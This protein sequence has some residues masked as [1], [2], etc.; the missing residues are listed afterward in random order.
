MEAIKEIEFGLCMFKCKK[1]VN[2][3]YVLHLHLCL[4]L[5]LLTLDEC[6][7]IK[8]NEKSTQEEY[9]SGQTMSGPAAFETGPLC[10]YGNPCPPEKVKAKYVVKAETSLQELS[11]KALL[12]PGTCRFL[13][14]SRSTCP[15]YRCACPKFY[16]LYPKA[17]VNID[18]FI[19]CLLRP[20]ERIPDGVKEFILGIAKQRLRVGQI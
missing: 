12:K 7:G 19:D 4:L 14:S 16:W 1:C 2:T 3:M 15:I 6:S 17:G 18:Q 10:P 11:A 13:D 20:G 5:G 8:E 9:F